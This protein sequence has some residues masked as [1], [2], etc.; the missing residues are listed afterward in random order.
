M[1]S[2]RS[3]TFQLGFDLVAMSWLDQLLGCQEQGVNRVIAH[4]RV[5]I[6]LRRADLFVS[7]CFFNGHDIFAR[8]IPAFYRQTLPLGM[9]TDTLR[10]DAGAD[11]RGSDD[12]PN[13]FPAQ[14]ENSSDMLSAEP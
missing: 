4:D 8:E 14:S 1:V 9:A 11:R 2:K 12:P 6:G 13:S 3:S 5:E 7:G 10:V